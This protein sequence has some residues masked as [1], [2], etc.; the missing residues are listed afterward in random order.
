MPIKMLA[1]LSGANTRRILKNLDQD[2]YADSWRKA[3]V[4]G[5][6]KMYGNAQVRAPRGE[7]N[8]LLSGLEMSVDAR[9]VPLWGRVKVETDN[10]GF[11]YPWA[12][13]GSKRIKY[14]YQSG[15]RKGKLT[16][17]WLSGSLGG[18]RSSV[19]ADLDT[20]AREIEAKWQA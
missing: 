17:S 10:E 6:K 11:R 16:K 14:R 19:N 2:L 18:V 7:T 3:L 8:Q 5:T 20:A 4:K 12:L 1:T 9:K 13:Q 15:P